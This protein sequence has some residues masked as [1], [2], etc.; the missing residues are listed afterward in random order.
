MTI[1]FF[2]AARMTPIVSNNTSEQTE[3]LK[4]MYYVPLPVN[5][6][7]VAYANAAAIKIR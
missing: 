3:Y 7:P 4:H 2:K 5:I 6:L 1:L